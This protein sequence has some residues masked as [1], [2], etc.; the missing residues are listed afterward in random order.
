MPSTALAN[1][2]I[3]EVGSR[4]A[5]AY[6]GKLVAELG[7]SV[8]K[9]EPL[10][11]DAL[12][13]RADDGDLLAAGMFSYLNASKRTISV[14][15]QRLPRNDV[16][17]DLFSR[18][19]IILTDLGPD[20]LPTEFDG[21][22]GPAR[23][24]VSDYGLDGPEH[25]RPATGLTIQSAAGWVI[26]R[27]QDRDEPVQVGGDPQEHITGSYAAVAVLV[28]AR[29]R[30]RG[31]PADGSVVSVD[32]SVLEAL[33]GAIPFHEVEGGA[34]PTMVDL[35]ARPF[36]LT[37]MQAS[38]GWV[39]LNC[40][41]GQ[42]WHDACALLGISEYAERRDEIRADRA[43][44]E[45]V[46]ARVQPWFMEHTAAEIVELAQTFRIP[47]A[48]LA[49]AKTIL[50]SPHLRERGFFVSNEVD[51]HRFEQPGSAYR[52]SATPVRVQTG[53]PTLEVQS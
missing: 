24:Y 21:P 25:G 22:G 44:L 36:P 31:L 35:A 28:A 13:R 49:S 11:G 8:I 9:V 14:D 5:V 16:F 33:H 46:R 18:S 7:A 15:L 34:D 30:A 29:A 53:I 47:A 43:L 17:R 2:R 10:N 50:N 12:R 40:L 19:D 48:V 45:V 4:V 23:V 52:L 6:A 27:G 1:L 38:D 26:W 37:I 42:Q 32:V 41:T 20:Q 51:G 39:G 3:V